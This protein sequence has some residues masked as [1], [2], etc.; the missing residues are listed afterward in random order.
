MT[1]VSKNYPQGFPPEILIRNF[2]CNKNPRTS[3]LNGEKHC[4]L[5]S[6]SPTWSDHSVHNPLQWPGL[7]IKMFEITVVV[8]FG[9]VVVEVVVQ[10][11]RLHSC[12]C[13]WSPT[14]TFV[15]P[16]HVLVL[17]FVPSPQLTEQ[18]LQLDQSLLAGVIF[19]LDLELRWVPT[20]P[21]PHHHFARHLSL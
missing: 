19:H 18:E 13:C 1:T 11:A 8:I 6:S 12:T 17:D 16:V 9:V 20:S 7:C 15:G 21:S 2:W 10:A 3:T 4:V 5:V 14:Q